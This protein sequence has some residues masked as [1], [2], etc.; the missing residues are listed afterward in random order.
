ML[1]VHWYLYDF[2]YWVDVALQEAAKHGH[3]G[4]VQLLVEA[5]ANI[6][7]YDEDGTP[8]IYAAIAGCGNVVE[9]LL[10]KGANVHCADEF[11]RTA[12]HAAASKGDVKAVRALIEYGAEVDEVRPRDEDGNTAL[13]LAAAEGHKDVVK[14]LPD[15]GANAHYINHCGDTA[16]QQAKIYKHENVVKLLGDEK[17]PLRGKLH[18]ENWRRPSLGGESR[19]STY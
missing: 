15:K 8:L 14:F 2:G 7:A 6:E 13:L 9:Y 1:L 5:G 12:L 10:K 17:L 4:V 3:K 16:L 11:G 19:I 18:A